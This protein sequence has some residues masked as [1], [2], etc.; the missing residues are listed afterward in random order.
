M[1]SPVFPAP[2]H[3]HDRCSAEALRHAETLC[4]QRAQKLT[5]TRRQVLEALLENH[6]P[7]GAYEIIDRAAKRHGTRHAPVTVY[8]ALDF[9]I[10]NGLAHRIESR[11]AYIACGHRHGASDLVVFLICERCGEVGEAPSQAVA[12]SLKA[13]TRA[14]GFTARTPVLEISGICGNCR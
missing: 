2:D 14:A 5:P 11:N 13:A 3:D 12:D 1:S 10:E 7:L 8:R 9:L 6:T 4:D